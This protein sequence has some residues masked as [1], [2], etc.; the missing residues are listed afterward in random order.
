M[1]THKSEISGLI[2]SNFDT[3]DL[4]DLL[5]RHKKE[6]SAISHER[7]SNLAEAIEPLIREVSKE[8][9]QHYLESSEESYRAAI[10]IN[11]EDSEAFG[12][13]DALYSE[14]PSDAQTARLMILLLKNLESAATKALN[15]MA[16][17][18]IRTGAL[19][20]REVSA[21]LN[22]SHVSVQRRTSEVR[23]RFSPDA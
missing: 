16:W 8:D 22:T 15:A 11:E 18:A 10:E 23:E 9:I 20:M 21:E 14:E 1:K 19:S 3:K 5:T 6:I 12:G 17:E 4:E 2:R 7:Q 13:K